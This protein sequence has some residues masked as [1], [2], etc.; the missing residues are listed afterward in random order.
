MPG[1]GKEA[2]AGEDVIVATWNLALGIFF[3]SRP[4]VGIGA[5][6]RIGADLLGRVLLAPGKFG[7]RSNRLS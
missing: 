1:L 5:S 3:L 4:P 2:P 7:S 6:R